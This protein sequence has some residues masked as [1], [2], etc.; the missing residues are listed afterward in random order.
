MYNT[1]SLI[2][3]R[4][5]KIL[6]LSSIIVS[7]SNTDDV[8]GIYH[9]ND[10]VTDKVYIEKIEDNTYKVFT[11]GS[12]SEIATIKNNSLEGTWK[13]PDDFEV[14]KDAGKMGRHVGKYKDGQFFIYLESINGRPWGNVVWTKFKKSEVKKVTD[15]TLYLSFDDGPL[16]GTREV[17]KIL[18][19]HNVP[20][21]FFLVGKHGTQLHN[22][23]KKTLEILKNT[24]KNILLANHSFSHANGRY[25]KYYS[26]PNNVLFD[27]EK[28]K[29]IFMDKR[30]WY[31]KIFRSSNMDANI[32]RFP[33]RNA[34]RIN[35]FT[36][37]DLK[38]VKPTLNKMPAH[39]QVFGWD[40]EWKMKKGQ[41]RENYKNVIKKI[42]K[43]FANHTTKFSNK[44]VLLAHDTMF[45][46]AKSQE[47]LVSFLQELKA[48]GY[49]FKLLNEF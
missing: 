4:F 32:V 1:Y 18:N 22:R 19:K 17:L 21:T 24:G 26:N 7:C 28:N 2:M 44:C 49:H 42:E 47:Q 30:P 27:I 9:V 15:K 25:L 37:Y 40:V 33:G 16:D 31:K 34:W 14:K 11:P 13:Y 46:S 48:K 29:Q 36:F 6:F 3:R 43:S 8:S 23:H 39:Y 20:A 35:D 38:S 41:P 45:K 5:F 12:W 10:D